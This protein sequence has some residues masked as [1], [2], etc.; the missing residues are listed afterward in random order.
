MH[1]P[2]TKAG[3]HLWHVQWSQTA[4]TTPPAIAAGTPV[5]TVT[6]SGGPTELIRDRI[7]H[8]RSQLE[9]AIVE[10]VAWF[11]NDRLHTSPG[12]LHLCLEPLPNLRGQNT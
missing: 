1:G 3:H 8:T 5:V 10:Y 9:L 2:P 6:D 7:W 11:N 12:G 4:W